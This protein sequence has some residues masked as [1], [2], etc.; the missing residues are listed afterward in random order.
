[1]HLSLSAACALTF[2]VGAVSTM[3]SID[4]KTPKEFGSVQWGRKLE[5]ALAK[6][7]SADMP[8]MLLFQ[9]VPG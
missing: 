2:A 7:A 1:M 6:A 9:E 8:V 5:P 3:T 4:D